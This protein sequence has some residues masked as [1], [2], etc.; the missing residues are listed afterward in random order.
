MRESTRSANWKREIGDW[1]TAKYPGKHLYKKKIP[2]SQSPTFQLFKLFAC[3]PSADP[4]LW[5]QKL[6][7]DTVYCVMCKSIVL[8]APSH[9]LAWL[10]TPPPSKYFSEIE[11]MLWC[12][13]VALRHC[14]GSCKLMVCMVHWSHPPMTQAAWHL[15]STSHCNCHR[16]QRNA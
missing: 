6:F 12:D 1:K 9:A 7:F 16:V 3:R 11:R 15:I 8:F 10:T 2:N 4:I 13:R 14:D 5:D